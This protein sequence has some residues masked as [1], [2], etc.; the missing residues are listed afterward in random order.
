MAVAA[1][2]LEGILDVV[3]DMEA[4]RKL[5]TDTAGSITEIAEWPYSTRLQAGRLG[6]A[7]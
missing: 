6:G 3:E 2:A 7:T 1:D 4:G 5:V